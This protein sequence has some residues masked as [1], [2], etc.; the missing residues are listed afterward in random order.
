MRR[1]LAVAVAAARARA[2][3][4]GCLTTQ[5]RTE[6]DPL[7]PGEQSRLD[8]PGRNRAEALGHLRL[9][10]SDL[11]LTVEETGYDDS[12]PGIMWFGDED[13]DMRLELIGP[14]GT[15]E[16][17]TRSVKVKADTNNRI[18][19]IEWFVSE[20]TGAESRAR[21]EADAEML[22]LSADD[23]ELWDLS[24][25]GVRSGE[26]ESHLWVIGL[27]VSPT[28]F[29]MDIQGNYNERTDNETYIYAIYL[30]PR[31]NTPEVKANWGNR[32]STI[33]PD[34]DDDWTC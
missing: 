7:A 31:Y 20:D 29:V 4:T 13:S 25:Q 33:I 30:E 21:L 1:P 34:L 27:G 19:M 9:D 28:G 23:L 16:S 8:E 14:N 12:L 22:G 15:L 11:C 5:T 6:A 24:V 2:L 10:L 17:T 3:L 18:R 32:G 26:N